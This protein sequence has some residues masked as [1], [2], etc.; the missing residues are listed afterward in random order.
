MTIPPKPFCAGSDTLAKITPALETRLREIKDY[1]ELSK[2]T[3][4]S[5]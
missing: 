2:S 3:D 5:F 1:E 4:G